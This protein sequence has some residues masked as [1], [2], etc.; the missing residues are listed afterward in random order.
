MPEFIVITILMRYQNTQ[1]Y[2]LN[3]RWL[4]P[5]HEKRKTVGYIRLIVLIMFV[6]LHIYLRSLL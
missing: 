6:T 4:L 1:T 3:L 5:G 2:Q